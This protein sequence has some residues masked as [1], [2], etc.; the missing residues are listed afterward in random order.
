MTIKTGGAVPRL[1]DG[2]PS[3]DLAGHWAEEGG[4]R[5]RTGLAGPRGMD[6]EIHRINRDGALACCDAV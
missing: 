2:S 6:P 4:R 3:I 5:R 1:G